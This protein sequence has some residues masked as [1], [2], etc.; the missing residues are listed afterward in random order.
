MPV[1]RYDQLFAWFSDYVRKA[2]LSGEYI[3]HEL[4]ADPGLDLCAWTLTGERGMALVSIWKDPADD[5]EVRIQLVGAGSLA[6]RDDPNLYRYIALRHSS[7]DYGIAAIA[8]PLSNGLVA[9]G[10]RLVIPSDLLSA[11]TFLS[12]ASPY[13]LYLIDH[14]PAVAQEIA[15]G[16]IAPFGGRLFEGSSSEDS[17]Q[18][19]AMTMPFD[20]R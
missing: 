5:N 10:S 6:M 20:N 17:T 4:F 7:L 19:F 14:L 8:R 9:Y 1:A 18:L 13:L 16:I 12:H 2:R 15:T 11:D 3:V